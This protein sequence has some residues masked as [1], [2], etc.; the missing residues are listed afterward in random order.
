MR[1]LRSFVQRGTLALALTCA[2]PVGA[3]QQNIRPMPSPAQFNYDLY[4]NTPDGT[5]RATYPGYIWDKLLSP[6][7]PV[8]TDANGFF[9]TSGCGGGSG[10]I[11]GVT[12]NGT[13]IQVTGSPCSGP[14]CTFGL[15]ID[16]ADVIAALGYTPAQG[17]PPGTVAYFA[18]QTAPAGWLFGRGQG[19]PTTG[20][21]AALFAAIGYTF[22][23]SGTT[24]NLPNCQGQFIRGFDAGGTVDPGRAFGSNQLDQFQGHAHNN[25]VAQTNGSPTMMVYTTTASGVPGNAG[26]TSH[27][28]NNTPQ[29]QGTTGPA[30]T[31][32][33]NGTPRTGTETRPVNIALNCIIKE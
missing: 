22:G 14:T 11:T 26:N 12:I 29:S 1:G 7:S 21:T 25:G 10:G 3:Q 28:D 33:T 17:D 8:C 31:D 19:E 20:P 32:G 16:S 23:G 24:F 4:P 18:G 30:V 2:L 27:A 6:N 15:S 9:A 5:T 13:N